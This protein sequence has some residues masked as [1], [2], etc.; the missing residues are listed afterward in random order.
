MTRIAFAFPLALVMAL[1]GCKDE[2]TPSAANEL[3]SPVVSKGGIIDD[4]IKPMP[5][6][7]VSK[8]GTND[9]GIKPRPTPVVNK[10]GNMNRGGIIDDGIK[11]RPRP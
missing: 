4:G 9:D 10:D 1:M 6:P 5:A 3:R 11:P 8:G 2:A 7:I